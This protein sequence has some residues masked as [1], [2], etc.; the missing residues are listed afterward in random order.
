MDWLK[1]FDWRKLW[2]PA[3]ALG[4]AVAIL[5][6][7]IKNRDI[8]VFGLGIMACGFGEQ[9]LEL[10]SR[11]NRPIGFAL[12]GLGIFLMAMSVYHLIA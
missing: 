5:A 10:Y 9:T 4:L 6:L 2:N 1:N 3:I 7:A 12:I 11:F 8:A